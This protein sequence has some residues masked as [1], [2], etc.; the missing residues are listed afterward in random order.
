MAAQY[1]ISHGW[2]LTGKFAI[3]DDT[4]TPRFEVQGRFALARKLSVRDMAGTEVAVIARQGLGSRY[5]I[6]AGGQETTVRPR[7][8][9][10]RRFEI[11][12]PAGPMEA[13]GNFSGRQYAITSG[14]TPAAAVTQL[15][16]LREQFAVEVADGQDAVLMLSVV[17]AIETIRDGRR[18]AAAA[19]AGAAAGG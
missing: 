5:Q 10:G 18:S 17:L 19:A 1:L 9:F 7:G 6:R 2:A 12:S 15:R 8:F 16:T 3:T 11:D 4:G 13:H 14:G